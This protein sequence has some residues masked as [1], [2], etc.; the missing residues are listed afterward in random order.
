MGM[1]LKRR[2]SNYFKTIK[3]ICMKAGHTFAIDFIIHLNRHDKASA[4]IFA[5]ITVNGDLN[6]TNGVIV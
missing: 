3:Q 6:P 4:L 5:R 2:I 1:I